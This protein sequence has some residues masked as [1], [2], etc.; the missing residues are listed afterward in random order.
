MI[1]FE[2]PAAFFFLLLIPVLYFLR[3]IKILTPV[4]FPLNLSDWGKENFKWERKFRKFLSVFVRI[5]VFAAYILLICA[6]A[7]PVKRSQK[8]VYSSRG[9]DIVFVL[10]ISPSMAAQDIAGSNRIDASRNAIKF[11]AEENTGCALGLVEMAQNAVMLVPPTMDRKIFFT[12][13]DSIKAGELGDGTAIGT[14]ISLAVYHLEKSTAGKKAIVL[15]TDGENN[16]G[17]I[18]PLTAAHLA[19]EK[20]ISLY[21]LGIG[22]KGTVHLEYADPKTGRVYSGFFDSDFNSANLAAIASE[23]KGKYFEVE[24]MASLSQSL[25]S[26]LK[27]EN[28]VQTYHIQSRDTPVYSQFLIAAVLLFVFAWIIRRIFLQEIL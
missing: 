5:L 12:R 20:E 27:D 21:V 26:V 15:I 9:A 25:A 16:S 22:T 3:Y 19:F 17:S 13:L 11:I 1:E 8:K 23:A 4:S 24:S 10:D 14:G 7:N 6:F 18:H 2:N 28:V